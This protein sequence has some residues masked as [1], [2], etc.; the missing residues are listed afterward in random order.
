MQNFRIL[1]QRLDKEVKEKN[2][3]KGLLSADDPLQVARTQK[4][5]FGILLC[6]LFS[7]G[8]AKNIVSFLQKLDFSLLHLNEAQIRKECKNLKYRFQNEED[9][10]QIFITLRRLHNEDS[11]ENFF[12]KM[13]LKEGSIVFG[14]KN[15]LACVRKV[16]EYSSYGY[17]FFF[18][19]EWKEAPTS[20]LKR[21]NMFLRWMVRKDELDLGL[22][23]KIHTKDLLIPLDVNTHQVSLKLGL[24]QRRSYDFKAVLELTHNLKKFDSNDP[25]KYDFALYRLGQNGTINEWI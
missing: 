22:F 5:E 17:D 4:N 12:S 24:L 15:F 10:R 25:I 16:N 8:K 21:Y 14:I 23:K 11:L 6:A 2:T 7:Y 9:I 1:K 3:I 13:Y 19:S 20:P 18:G